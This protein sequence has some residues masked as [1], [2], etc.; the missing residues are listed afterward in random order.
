M[1]FNFIF[2]SV[3]VYKVKNLF[4]LILF[5][6]LSILIKLLNCF[7]GRVKFVYFFMIKFN[8]IVFFGLS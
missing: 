2:L 3:D 5:L 1:F 8:D 7:F 4:Y 6:K